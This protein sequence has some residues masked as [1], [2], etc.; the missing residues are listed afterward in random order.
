MDLNIPGIQIE[1]TL[2]GDDQIA[3]YRGRL[4]ADG[5]AILLKTITAPGLN[6]DVLEDPAVIQALRYRHP[7]FNRI[8][9][10][11]LDDQ[12]VF[13]A[14]EWIGGATLDE[15][16][17]ERGALRE[18]NALSF[19][20]GVAS[21][22][23]DAWQEKRIYHGCL[24]LDHIIVDPEGMIRLTGHGLAPLYAQ[25][26][27][28]LGPDA[29]KTSPYFVSP[30][31]AHNLKDLDCRSD[32]Y[33][34][35]ALLYQLLTGV[36]PFG[37]YEDEE[38]PARHVH[39][40]LPD[41]LDLNPAMSQP[42]A[43][44]IE[45]MM[46][47]IRALRPATWDVILQDIESVRSG[48]IPLTA[49]LEEGVSTVLRGSRREPFTPGDAPMA[50]DATAPTENEEE[51]VELE[52]AP[53][54]HDQAMINM[55]MAD[56]SGDEKKKSGFFERIPAQGPKSDSVRLSR[57]ALQK[58]EAVAEPTPPTRHRLVVSKDLR[59][60]VSRVRRK[61]NVQRKITNLTTLV[62]VG[63]L[64]W[65]AAIFVVKPLPQSG[66]WSN[67]NAVL[68]DIGTVIEEEQKKFQPEPERRAPTLSDLERDALRSEVSEMLRPDRTAPEPARQTP[69]SA[70]P[71][72]EPATDRRVETPREEP[73]ARR[74]E[75]ANGRKWNHPDFIRGA[76]LYNEA[77]RGFK[78]YSQ[79]RRN[80]SQLA[81]LETQAKQAAEYF[82]KC[83]DQAPDF[84]PIDA[85]LQNCYRLIFDI[86]QN[87]TL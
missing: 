54:E 63:G 26:G 79:T 17:Q 39:D 65:V 77:V 22:L 12:T 47:K 7:G 67:P 59:T 1:E 87:R 33:S 10:A 21:I 32:I 18:K 72:R 19:V 86:R 28:L 25:A 16:I 23:A 78:E 4:E 49:R 3:S 30:E 45:K 41:A 48:R 15:I 84:V 36:Q 11:G 9:D 51:V 70:P 57:E 2:H 42:C 81:G 71:T 62:I 53:E 75:P 27:R 76:R 73:P 60:E 74:T 82:E 35:G 46:I 37:E 29:L 50:T 64:L 43:W 55:F 56:D 83:K 44:L 5:R 6:A 13:L 34:M 24:A 40:Q 69:P 38:I 66:G 14:Y 31:L 8:V 85:Y 68:E 58:D 52:A 80:K 61:S 20:E